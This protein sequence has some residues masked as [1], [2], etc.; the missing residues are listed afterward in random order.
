MAIQSATSASEQRLTIPWD[1]SEWID[2]N[3]LRAWVDEEIG[4]LDWSN[5]ELLKF[6]SENP[7]YHP[8][9]LLTLLHYA[10]ATGLYESEEI[11]KL[12]HTDASLK[13]ICGQ[14]RPSTSMLDRFRRDNRG[15]LKWG[16][17][18]ILK[19]AFRSKYQLNL[20]PPG[21]RRYLE[22]SATERLDLARH[23]DRAG[24]GA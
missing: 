14:Y 6:L 10:Y 9:L 18:Q 21:L 1:I 22:E 3:T 17:G 15:L 23:M 5:P 13:E 16:L 8:R 19:R 7:N 11:S 20:L 4:A 12:C 2:K 24:Q